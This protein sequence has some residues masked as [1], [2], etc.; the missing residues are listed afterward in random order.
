MSYQEKNI[1]VSVILNLLISL[2]FLVNV[3]QM[4]QQGGLEPERSYA[5]WATVIIVGIIANVISSVLTNVILTVIQT[6]RNEEVDTD[7]VEDERDKM[8]GLKG[9][10]NGYVMFSVGAVIAMGTMVLGQPP[11]VM[12]N[13]L[14]FSAI[15][16]TAITEAS[17]LYFYRRG[18]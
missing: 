6:V 8:I 14:T 11:L 10:R 16:S 17:Q 18:F 1:T 3:F 7:F 13:I 4:V 12:F 15:F 9:M 2:Y 5:L